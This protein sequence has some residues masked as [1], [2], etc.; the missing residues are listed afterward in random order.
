MIDTQHSASAFQRIVPVF[1]LLLLR[2]KPDGR[3]RL[4]CEARINIKVVDRAL[5]ITE[6]AGSPI[7]MIQHR[8]LFVH[9]NHQSGGL[10]ITV[11]IAG[12]PSSRRGSIVAGFVLGTL[13]MLGF[14]LLTFAWVV[15]RRSRGF[16]G[17]LQLDAGFRGRLAVRL[18]GFLRL[19]AGL[20]GRLVVGL[21]GFLRL[22]IKLLGW[23]AVRFRWFLRLDARLLGRLAVRLLEALRTRRLPRY[24]VVLLVDAHNGDTFLVFDSYHRD[25]FIDIDVH[26]RSSF[27]AILLVFAATIM[28][29]IR[30]WR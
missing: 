15:D 6:N 27:I 9:R 11:E 25:L 19:D 4:A 14:L 30:C 12:T 22:D 18:L 29:H 23:L 17:F 2:E 20:L 24:S 16:L 3:A 8:A 13:V 7:T 10:P 1:E 5:A 21:L 26:S 28:I